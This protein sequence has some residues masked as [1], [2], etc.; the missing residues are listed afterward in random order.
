[1]YALFLSTV[2]E[3]GYGI[4]VL[5]LYLVGLVVSAAPPAPAS[6]QWNW[7]RLP[8]AETCPDGGD[9][10]RQ[11]AERL[12][13]DPFDPT[14]ALILEAVV[15]RRPTGWRVRLFVRGRGGAIR[16]SRVLR[17][18]GD[19]CSVMVEAVVLAA[20][21]SID[22]EALTRAAPPPEP[23][24]AAPAP[25]PPEP[26]AAPVPA[27]I[28]AD[29]VVATQVR[30][31]VNVGTLPAATFGIGL[32]VELPLTSAFFGGA[33]FT[34]WGAQRSGPLDVG[35]AAGWLEGGWA[36]FRGPLRLAVGV[37]AYAGALWV[38]PTATPT[39]APVDPGQFAWFA[40]AP[41]IRGSW[42]PIELLHLSLE[43][44]M[45]VSVTRQPF[46]VDGV[47][48]FR[49]SPAAFQA[50]FGIGLAI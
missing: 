44:E 28:E 41:A 25:A 12:G 15:D 32:A 36:P 45:P 6:V 40:V 37:R 3:S 14:G 49:E 7:S 5:G 35:L 20:V 10:A 27:T 16:G 29:T 47:T 43:V 1:M 34:L 30:T 22:P 18:D 24:R 33:G 26:P 31:S 46:Q 13:R 2:R 50:S 4:E 17:A 19:D 42:S 21:L 8:G 23:A 48:V 39:F 11:I 38:A 9:L